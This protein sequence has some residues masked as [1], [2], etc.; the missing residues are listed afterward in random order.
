MERATES[1]WLKWF[2][3]NCDFG[4]ASDDVMCALK[5]QFMEY[6]GKALPEGYGDE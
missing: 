1:E 6:T 2:Y 5:D 3:C 4:P